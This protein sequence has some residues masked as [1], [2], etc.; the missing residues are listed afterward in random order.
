MERLNELLRAYGRSAEAEVRAT[1]AA[2]RLLRR[3]ENGTKGNLELRYL[4]E[5]LVERLA[6][7]EQTQLVSDIRKFA[8]VLQSIQIPL[9]PNKRRLEEVE[10]DARRK[11][12]KRDL[13]DAQ[14][15]YNYLIPLPVPQ[16][17][18]KRSTVASLLN[19]P[20][21]PNRS[22][23][24]PEPASLPALYGIIQSL[25]PERGK[26]VDV[27]ARLADG[28]RKPQASLAESIEILYD[29]VQLAAKLCAPARDA[30][31]RDL[32]AQVEACREHAARGTDEALLREK[33][34]EAK[35]AT[36]RLLQSMQRD[37]QLFELGLTAA[38]NSE[39][40]LLRTVKAEAMKREMEA[41]KTSDGQEALSEAAAWVRACLGDAA[42]L[43]RQNL[44]TALIEALF[45]PSPVTIGRDSAEQKVIPP[46]FALAME[47]LFLLQNRL[48]A[49][50]VL[51]TLA[52]LVPLTSSGGEW[53]ERVHTLLLSEIDPV[54]G[55]TEILKLGNV[56]D[57]IIRAVRPGAEQE[58]KLR[59]SVE[60]MVS[61]GDPVYKLLSSRLRTAFG[62]GGTAVEAVKGF[63][64]IP[65]PAELK[66]ID[67]SIKAV[68]DWACESWQIPSVA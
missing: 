66:H 21:S 39:E 40:E 12:R 11:R 26:F 59:A 37:M 8:T 17:G 65:L 29:L 44:R 61:L 68:L 47:H 32:M 52:I 45:R 22:D 38:C 63:Q 14:L 60:R 3:L 58:I 1:R 5:D 2:V 27:K 25:V 53:A 9:K 41:V 13:Q 34:E 51:A 23:P 30:Q 50:V 48:Q 64:T 54:A 43:D 19:Q 57:E 35:R 55:T 42:K 46:I 16:Q 15:L 49:A 56:A 31:A 33:W 18:Q 7:R 36:A 4:L 24:S 20:P 67:L 10:A 62:T 28:C 6:S